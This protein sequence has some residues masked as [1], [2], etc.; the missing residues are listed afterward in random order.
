[1]KTNFNFILTESQLKALM[2]LVEAQRELVYHLQKF[3]EAQQ[4]KVEELEYITARA[5]EVQK[6]KHQCSNLAFLE[7]LS[8]EQKKQI[9]S[10]LILRHIRV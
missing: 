9:N 3:K 1:M 4:K 8:P 6:I 10:M 5:S 2:R 7:S